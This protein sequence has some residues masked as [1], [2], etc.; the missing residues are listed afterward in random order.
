MNGMAFQLWRICL[1]LTQALPTAHLGAPEKVIELHATMDHPQGI[2]VE[3]ERLWVTW[4]D[5]K[6]KAGYLGEFELSTGK[7][8]RSIPI[9][10]GERYH[11]GGISADGG[12]LWIPVAEYKPHSSSVIQR[13]NR[14]T[15]DL[16][17]EFEVPD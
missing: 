14:K 8:L 6:E 16:E 15:L 9:H 5:R 3:G 7:L 4:V 12:S 11:P 17:S 10:Q 13:R 1:A 2:E